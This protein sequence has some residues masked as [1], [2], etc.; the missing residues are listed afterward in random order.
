MS[1]LE[2]YG[3][4]DVGYDKRVVGNGVHMVGVTKESGRV[5]IL[6]NGVYVGTVN[7]MHPKKAF[8]GSAQLYISRDTDLWLN[9]AVR[10]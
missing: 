1:G 2:E 10:E 9:E 7:S 8:N 5:M 3:L 6:A 4:R